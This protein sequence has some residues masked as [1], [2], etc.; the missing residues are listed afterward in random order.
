[1]VR[2]F[3]APDAVV[4]EVSDDGKGFVPPDGSREA[5]GVIGMRE[6]AAQL[7]GHVTIDGR[8]GRGT[9]VRLEL[10]VTRK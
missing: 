7:G 2:L 9:R 5:L 10:P 4:L 8:G 6:R 1:M 3:R